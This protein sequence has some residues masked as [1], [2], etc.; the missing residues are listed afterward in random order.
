MGGSV[1]L[2]EAS[3]AAELQ[4]RAVVKLHLVGMPVYLDADDARRRV[5]RLHVLAYGRQH[6]ARRHGLGAAVHFL[7]VAVVVELH[8][9]AVVE[10]HV[11]LVAAEGLR[12]QLDVVHLGLGEISAEHGLRL[13]RQ[14][15]GVAHHAAPGAHGAQPQDQACQ[16]CQNLFHTNVNFILN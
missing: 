16:D 8:L 13:L 4:V 7:P 9:C 1:D 12:L 5:I 6:Q 10:D 2:D 14:N 15:F 11:I 3:V